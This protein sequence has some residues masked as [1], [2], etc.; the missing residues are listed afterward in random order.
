MDLWIRSQ[1]KTKLIK[2]ENIMIIEDVIEG[3]TIVDV[4]KGETIQPPI[5]SKIMIIASD[6]VVGTYNTK[7]RALQV[8]DDITNFL[9]RELKIINSSYQN[10]DIEIKSKSYVDDC[11]VYEMPE[12]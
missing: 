2:V 3:M 1:D 7:E 10:A 8:L 9:L 6:I 11:K 5:K 4:S 12:V